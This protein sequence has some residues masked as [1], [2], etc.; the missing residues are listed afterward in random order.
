MGTGQKDRKKNRTERHQEGKGAVIWTEMEKEAAGK[1]KTGR[2][3]EMEEERE[4]TIRVGG[5]KEIGEK[6]LGW[7]AKWRGSEKEGKE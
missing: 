1:G 4:R 5:R 3:T 2:K 7:A 6:I